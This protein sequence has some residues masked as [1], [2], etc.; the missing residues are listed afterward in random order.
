MDEDDVSITACKMVCRAL[1]VGII[2]AG[3]ACSIPAAGALAAPETASDQPSPSGTSTL[4]LRGL[5]K[6]SG[7]PTDIIAPI[8]RQ[9]AFPQ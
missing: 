3:L 1:M 6:I 5:D 2:L 4:I 8:G 7:Q 9:V